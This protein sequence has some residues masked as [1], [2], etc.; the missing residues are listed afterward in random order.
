MTDK[1]DSILFNSA[2]LP[3]WVALRNDLSYVEVNEEA[4][5]FYGYSKTEF[6]ALKAFDLRDAGDINFLVQRTSEFVDFR[7]EGAVHKKKNGERVYVEIIGKTIEYKGHE[8]YLVTA[9]DIS[10]RKKAEE[11]LRSNQ[12]LLL[13]SQEMGKIGSW[14]VVLLDYD[15]WDKNPCTWSDESYRIFGY[16]PNS[17]SVNFPFFLEHIH[18]EDKHLV[19]GNLEGLFSSDEL[20]EVEYRIVLKNGDVKYIFGRLR[21][22]FDKEKKAPLKMIGM[23]QDV[24]GKKIAEEKLKTETQLLHTSQEMGKI[25]SWEIILKDLTNWKNN[26][27]I[28]SDEAYRIFNSEP[29][30]E[31]SFE[32]FTKMIHPEDVH[33]IIM[34]PED[35]FPS[36]EAKKSHHSE[37]RIIMPDGS[38]KHIHGAFDI[39][40]GEN[41]LP[42]KITGISQDITERKKLEIELENYNKRLEEEIA[43]QTHELVLANKNLDSFNYSISHDMRTPL[44]GIEMYVELLKENLKNDPENLE[45]T[46]KIEDGIQEIKN[47][48]A[49][50]LEF[51]K[52]SKVDLIKEEINMAE[53]INRS[54]DSLCDKNTKLNFEI[55]D[56]PSLYADKV[57]IRN[58]LCNLVSNAIK[59]SSKKSNPEIQISGKT[60]NDYVVYY[61]K[62]NGHGFDKKLKSKLFKPFSRLHNDSEF[63]GNGA[64]LAI[65]ERI[66]AR[67]GGSIW[68][69]SE[70]GKGATFYFK[71]PNPK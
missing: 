10:E 68:A 33:K 50:L 34:R 57:L 23:V 52:Y 9:L 48:I 43:K 59:Y 44:R 58:V 54:I 21:V 1:L 61:V 29:G 47:M 64:G 71:L 22:I 66:I 27:T 32:N 69:E 4:L 24:T 6:L 28:L 12:E 31:I 39:V 15:N 42:I 45:S 41:N 30:R 38:C 11:K 65:A 7:V 17:I 14:E 19:V 16:E 40:F 51:S 25:G 37:Y 2:P 20:H 13:T 5:K 53:E 62:D 60:E 46:I 36:S 63:E 67:H 26:P 3:M 49:S 56:T 8:A 70:M 35:F 55:L 18:P